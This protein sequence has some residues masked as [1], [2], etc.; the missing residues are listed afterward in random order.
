MH[1]IKFHKIST[2]E[3][4]WGSLTKILPN[5]GFEQVKET[6]SMVILCCID[7]WER[8]DGILGY[9]PVLGC[10]LSD[11][12][13]YRKTL[14]QP[15]LEKYFTC[16]YFKNQVFVFQNHMISNSMLSIKDFRSKDHCWRPQTKISSSFI[17]FDIS[18]AE[19]VQS[20]LSSDRS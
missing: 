14:T 12:S 18:W 5:S 15:R 10:N 3:Q 7:A 19:K 13:K 4:L 20:Y 9:Y 6:Y 2:T 16:L 8:I 1:E 17:C 11:K